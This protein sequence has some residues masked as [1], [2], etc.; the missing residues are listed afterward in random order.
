MEAA[1]AAD[2]SYVQAETYR[3]QQA[4]ESC[5]MY[6]H[7]QAAVA[8]PV[9]VSSESAPSESSL[10]DPSSS[11]FC[12]SRLMGALARPQ[13]AHRELLLYDG[14]SFLLSVGLLEVER[15]PSYA[16]VFLSWRVS[17]YEA[18]RRAAT[19]RGVRRRLA[20]EHP[21]Q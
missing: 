3:T 17:N 16:V 13:A 6:T 11:V 2:R 18:R 5:Y 20:A 8:L 19:P 21:P 10:I 4:D 1:V 12:W 7:I 9:T 14:R 15:R